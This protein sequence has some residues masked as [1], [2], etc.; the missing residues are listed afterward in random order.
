MKPGSVSMPRFPIDPEDR[1]PL[2][3]TGERVPAIGI[4]TYGIRSYADAEQ[5]IVHAIELGLNMID[6]AEMYGNGLA[7][8]MVCRIVK[9]VG[10]DRV[11]ITTKLLPHRFTDPDTAVRAAEASARRMCVET[12]DLVLIHWPNDVLPIHVQIRALEAIAERGLARYIGVSNF[13][14]SEL[15]EAIESTSKYEIVVNQVKYSVLDKAIE[16][17]L[18]PFCIKNNILIQAYT[19]LERGAVARHPTIISVANRYGKTPVQVALNFLISRP[20]VVAIPKTERIER[21]DEFYGALGWRLAPQD[22]ELLEK[23]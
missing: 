3:S 23:V 10:R 17:N 21:V 5:A 20:M 15:R 9:K 6:T 14:L 8:E 19:P 2:G 12:I 16:K 18:L 11:F 22:I 13:R 1:K 7:E 4:G